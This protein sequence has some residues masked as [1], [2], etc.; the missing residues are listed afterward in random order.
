MMISKATIALVSVAILPFSPNCMAGTADA[1]MT[2]NYFRLNVRN[3]PSGVYE[4]TSEDM[5]FVHVRTPYKGNETP[6]EMESVELQTANKLLLDWVVSRQETPEPVLPDGLEFVRSF[7]R[8]AY[9]EWGR[10]FNWSFKGVSRALTEERSDERLYTVIYDKK[11]VLASVPATFFKPIEVE[12]W[13][14]GLHE[15]VSDV[16]VVRGELS[17]MWRIGALDCLD[18]SRA[19][20]AKFPDVRSPCFVS[21]LKSYQQSVRASWRDVCSPSLSEY[22]DVRNRLDGYLS[23]SEKAHEL[24][25]SA[26]SLCL[27]T[28]RTSWSERKISESVTTNSIVDVV[29]N[30]IDSAVTRTNE[31][32][33]SGTSVDGMSVMAC[34]NRLDVMSCFIDKFD[35]ITTETIVTKR[36]VCRRIEKCDTHYRGEP[37]FEKMFLSSGCLAVETKERT[38]LGLRA[39]KAF[40]EQMEMSQRKRLILS[41]LRENPSDKV[42]WNLLG[43]LLKEE[44]DSLGA[45]VC[46]RNSLRI[47]RAYDFA[48][49]NLA[50]TYHELGYQK[51]A[52]ACAM[53][54]RGI[55]DNDWC[56]RHS[57]AVL[58]ARKKK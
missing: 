48:L 11:D 5:L 1:A 46:Y 37:L 36:V 22:E 24:L 49:T 9:P 7:V 40:F 35:V 10:V 55:T 31:S 8:Q 57:E 23:S 27:P 32:V 38:R 3:E 13:L 39:E 47:D 14:R 56:V 42:L 19:S 53:L 44:D 15:L 43:R 20:K 16:Y 18:V 28:I 29:T 25:R 4:W 12:S 50:E 6:E 33:V 26:R 30:V 54:A 17:F 52:R 58:S 34:G 51:L 2:E 45:L 41:G 21:E